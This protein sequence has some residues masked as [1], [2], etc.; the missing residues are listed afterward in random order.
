L[1]L[2]DQT[3]IC[4]VVTDLT[5]QKAEETLRSAKEVAERANLAKDNF[6]AALSHEL[7][8]PLTPALVAISALQEDETLPP[9][10]LADL[11]M[12]QR[13]IE[14]EARLIDDLLD[15]TRIARGKLEL[16][17]APLDLHVVLRRAVDV[18]LPS[19]EAKRTNVA[20]TLNATN[21]VAMG[22][23]V[24][25]EQ[26]FW[27]VI[28]NAVKFTPTGGAIR[29]FTHDAEPQV[30]Q[31]T[32]TDS[33]IGFDPADAPRI[34][35]SFEQVERTR[36]ARFGGLGL[37]L[38]ISRSIVIAHGGE[39]W[40]ESPGPNL[41]ATFHVRL[42]LCQPVSSSLLT[43]DAPSASPPVR[44]LRILLVEDHADTRKILQWVLKGKGHSVET[45]GSADEALALAGRQEFDLLISD[46]GL[47]DLS[48]TEL[49]T[50]LRDRY[51]L[52]GIAVS[53]Y[54]AK[55][56]VRQSK[57]A[58]FDCHLTKPINPTIVDQMVAQIAA[59]L[60]REQR[61]STKS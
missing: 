14:T 5:P 44:G 51:S 3:V 30:F 28:H 11:A 36:A 34:F 33:G 53:G 39:I 48:G 52:R 40:A 61:N 10:V 8:T 9:Y 24:R 50:I 60:E 31:V 21:T 58:G 57:A 7:R 1:P 2:S 38:S 59:K 15:V 49:M 47:P 54:G 19:A 18:C 16:Q 45:A 46:L 27:N 26:V 29:V 20:V 4:L 43:T 32:V 22:D 55:K 12:V 25:L 13:N 17:E 35:E 42:P 37:G 23:A 41:G 6:L 56:D